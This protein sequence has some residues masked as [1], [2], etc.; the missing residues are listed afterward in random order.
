MSLSFGITISEVQNI[1]VSKGIIMILFG[2]Q[3][4]ERRNSLANFIPMYHN[5]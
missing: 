1:R 3:I 2:R 5:N 4:K